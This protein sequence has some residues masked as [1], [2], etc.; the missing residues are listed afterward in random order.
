[1]YKFVE[2]QQSK[3]YALDEAIAEVEAEVASTGKNSGSK[4]YKYPSGQKFTINYKNVYE[5]MTTLGGM[6]EHWRG[7]P[8]FAMFDIDGR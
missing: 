4:E 2:S 3:L 5:N 7:V 1:M 8:A 6:P